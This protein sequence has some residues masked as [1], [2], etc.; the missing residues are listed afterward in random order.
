MVDDF[1]TYKGAL[2][3]GIGQGNVISY[4]RSWTIR[5][6]QPT[7]GPNRIIFYPSLVMGVDEEGDWYED[8]VVHLPIRSQPNVRRINNLMRSP[9]AKG[10]V[11]GD[12]YWRYVGRK[13]EDVTRVLKKMKEDGVKL[14]YA[15]MKRAL[16]KARIMVA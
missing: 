12:G 14:D 1:T 13:K 10:W 6:K 5:L 11:E 2:R 16:D 4:N 15:V 3:R 8:T 7:S 9:A